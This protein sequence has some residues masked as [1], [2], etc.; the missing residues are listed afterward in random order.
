M[1]ETFPNYAGRSDVDIPL[2]EEL[3]LAGIFVERLP[4]CCRKDRGEV[5]TIVI[6]TLH[7]WSFERFWYYWVCKGPGIPIDA[8]MKL[9]EK[10]G[11]VV[12]VD[13]HCGCPSPLERFK[14][15][16]TG[17]YHVDTLRGLKALADTI[18][19]VVE[20]ANV[21]QEVANA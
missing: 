5:K 11:K 14:G 3:E 13:G 1:S 6:G 17:S 18:R 7:G 20:K 10:Y 4:E 16:G 9:H 15:L 8:A 2:E 21:I 19:E 12:R